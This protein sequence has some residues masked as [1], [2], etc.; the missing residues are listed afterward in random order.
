VQGFPPGSAELRQ[1]IFRVHPWISIFADYFP[2]AAPWVAVQFLDDFYNPG[3]MWI[4]MDI[5]DKGKKIIVFI[6]ED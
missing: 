6:T 3:A 2:V 4:E 1:N 5:A